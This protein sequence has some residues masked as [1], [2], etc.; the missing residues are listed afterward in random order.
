M[1]RRAYAHFVA[2]IAVS[3]L[4]LGFATPLAAHTGQQAFD[5]LESI[6]GE[7]SH[8]S[9][10]ISLNLSGQF[11]PLTGKDLIYAIFPKASLA[12]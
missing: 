5:T 12:N 6:T 9:S 11:A 7:Q 10:P 4:T 3:I 1:Y 2:A 8:L